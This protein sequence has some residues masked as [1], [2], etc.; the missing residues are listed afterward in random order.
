MIA[1]LRSTLEDESGKPSATRLA[2]AT[3][4]V[5]VGILAIAALWAGKDA[6]QYAIQ[7]QAALLAFAA[8]AIGASAAK[9]AAVAKH[10]NGK[11]TA[12]EPRDP[13]SPPA[14]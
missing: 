7:A 13:S 10:T 2:A 4:M 14:A 8:T 9:S 6:A 3:A 5:L 1:W 12:H 11:G